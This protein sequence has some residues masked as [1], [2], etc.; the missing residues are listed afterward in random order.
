ML[1]GVVRQV[2]YVMEESLCVL[3]HQ[4]VDAYCAMI[5]EIASFRCQVVSTF[6]V[7]YTVPERKRGVVAV[8]ALTQYLSAKVT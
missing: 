5:D 1:T 2:T 4:N 6:L 3:T 8:V 7:S